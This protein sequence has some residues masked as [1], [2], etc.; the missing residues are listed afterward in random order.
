MGE[1]VGKAAFTE[2]EKDKCRSIELLRD[3]G[4]L[5]H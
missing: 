3:P 5:L 2:V 1:I 4:A